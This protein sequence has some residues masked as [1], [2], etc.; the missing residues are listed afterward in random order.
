MKTV[1]VAVFLKKTADDLVGVSMRA[2][3]EV[4]VARVARDF[5]GGGHRNAAGFKITHASL[6]QI[7]EQLL[8]KLL[9]LV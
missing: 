6:A 5:G 2:K 1:K 4:D 3:G 9:P 8:A 7:K